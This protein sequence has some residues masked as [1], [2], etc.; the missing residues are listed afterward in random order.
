MLLVAIAQLG[1]AVQQ[2]VTP[3]GGNLG[4]TV[5]H[6]VFGLISGIKILAYSQYSEAKAAVE[7]RFSFVISRTAP[8]FH[9]N[10]AFL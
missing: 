8:E 3:Q 6:C 7:I 2:D 9:A 1:H 10:G 5:T 4:G